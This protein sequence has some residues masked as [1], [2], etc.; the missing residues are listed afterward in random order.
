M[1]RKLNKKDAIVPTHDSSNTVDHGDNCDRDGRCCICGRPICPRCTSWRSW[2]FY[3]MLTCLICSGGF[4]PDEI[5][6][7]NS[8]R[9]K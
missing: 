7:P 3:E 2:T 6:L 5:K 8:W 9:Q 1:R 4:K